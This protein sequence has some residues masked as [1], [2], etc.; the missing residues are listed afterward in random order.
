MS[1]IGNLLM[2][3]NEARTEEETI[4]QDRV[5]DLVAEITSSAAQFGYATPGVRLITLGLRAVAKWRQ[6]NNTVNICNEV[7][8][9]KGNE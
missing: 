1:S 5:G 2:R 8:N 7:L 4:W 6:D 9:Y 3:V